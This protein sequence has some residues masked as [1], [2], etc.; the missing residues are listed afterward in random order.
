M[1]YIY[2]DDNNIGRIELRPLEFMNKLEI[3]KK[4]VELFSSY[5]KKK[6]KY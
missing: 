6:I 2:V 1:D 3:K 4:S 5:I